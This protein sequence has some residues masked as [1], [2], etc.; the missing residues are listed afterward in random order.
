MGTKKKN[1]K[2]Q[3]WSELKKEHFK[4]NPEEAYDYLRASLEENAD[5]PEAIIEAI[6]SVAEAL[7][8][9]LEDVAKKA[10][11]QPSTIYK[12][13]GKDG[14]PTIQTLTAIL[15]AMGLRLSIEKNVG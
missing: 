14:N 7:D 3:T 6:R 9:S 12:A 13:L 10:K 15:N 5:I 4:E 2:L 8:M 11:I 1:P